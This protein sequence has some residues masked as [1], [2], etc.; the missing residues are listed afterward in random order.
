MFLPTTNILKQNGDRIMKAELRLVGLEFDAPSYEVPELPKEMR[1][2]DDIT[3]DVSKVALFLYRGFMGVGEEF[4]LDLIHM[5]VE[6][7]RNC[8]GF[9][10]KFEDLTCE[11]LGEFTVTIGGENGSILLV[12]EEVFT[13]FMH[14][15]AIAVTDHLGYEVVLERPS[16]GEDL[17]G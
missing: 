15:L 7:S 2:T 12:R 6:E 11:H 8:V 9:E 16:F 17:F 4:E 10:V 14:Q 5:W 13:I 1:L 3:V